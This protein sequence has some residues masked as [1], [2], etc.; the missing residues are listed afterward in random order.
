MGFLYWRWDCQ[1]RVRIE[2][3]MRRFLRII[4]IGGGASGLYNK[5]FSRQEVASGETRP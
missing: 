1:A 4:L 3:D 2:G 5:D